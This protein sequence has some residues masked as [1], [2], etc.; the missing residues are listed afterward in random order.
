MAGLIPDARIPRRIAIGYAVLALAIIISAA[1]AFL[2]LDR[3]ERDRARGDLARASAEATSRFADQAEALVASLPARAGAAHPAAAAGFFAEAVA[4]GPSGGRIF[5]PP[6]PPD[7]P[8]ADE[9]GMDL[10]REGAMLAAAGR[11]IEA[12]DRYGL[13]FRAATAETAWSALLG[14]ASIY[15]RAG[16]RAQAIAF[17]DRAAS[18]SSL[19]RLHLTARLRHAE[20]LARGA[21][22]EAARSA[23]A[24][25]LEDLAATCAT[26]TTSEP[27][28][29][30]P[31]AAKFLADR[32][33]A[34]MR[35]LGD[36]SADGLV[37]RIDEAIASRRRVDAIARLMALRPSGARFVRIEDG[38]PLA[39]V[40][41]R[42]TGGATEAFLLRW[43]AWQER[44][45]EICGR[46]RAGSFEVT[47]DLVPPEAV[48]PR[49]ALAVAARPD[50]ADALAR[51][52]AR[53]RLRNALIA[54]A[55]AVLFLA[56]AGLGARNLA[57]AARLTR[58]RAEF[59]LSA[60]HQIRTPITLIRA[61]A[62]TIATRDLDESARRPYLRT[63][64]TESRRLS[65]IVARILAPRGLGRIAT[66]ERTPHDL[67]DL[68]REAAASIEPIVREAGLAC[69][70]DAPE[71]VEAIV[72]AE[73][74]I[75]AL[76]A[77]LE[78][79]LKYMPSDLA[80][81]RKA[82]IVRVRR[83]G[84]RALIEVADRGIGIAAARARGPRGAGLGLSIV[85]RI[86]REHG[87]A[88]EI[89][90]NEPFGTT[91]RIRV[92]LGGDRDGHA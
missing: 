81:D 53:S 19:P 87:G 63:L 43:E 56:A 74:I 8:P 13:A 11:D 54:G 75:N 9:P 60:S 26:W 61:A 33:A 31:D 91:V 15:E 55:L 84:D 85:R 37:A 70:V 58:A 44:M 78:N 16:D 76:L 28:A 68:A 89:D 30:D 12:L 83:D 49:E 47:F 51:A 92:P 40:Y 45:R 57:R 39:V 35:T 17:L 73:A 18:S 88:V 90:G 32:A 2:L 22:P 82:I 24:S 29:L 36:P 25:L 66:G 46:I 7:V 21:D 34:G 20:I 80:A 62:E 77:L 1:G 5:P 50:P 48:A 4:V 27:R 64:V 52:L 72:D 42:S 10:V 23:Y 67:G 79:A 41:T 65:E 38:E 86:A 71:A 59:A 6:A 3:T 69:D 14:M